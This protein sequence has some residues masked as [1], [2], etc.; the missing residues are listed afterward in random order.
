MMQTF[1]YILMF[2]VIIPVIL[3]ICFFLA[4]L[5]SDGEWPLTVW[6][7]CAIALMVVL[8]CLGKKDEVRKVYIV[9]SCQQHKVNKNG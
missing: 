8:S 6:I 3:F 9:N 4:E 5:I 1:A 7:I 2:V